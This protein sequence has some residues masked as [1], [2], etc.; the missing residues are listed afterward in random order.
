MLSVGTMAWAETWPPWERHGR[1]APHPFLV[2]RLYPNQNRLI[3]PISHSGG[4]TSRGVMLLPVNLPSAF[5]PEGILS[6]AC[7][8]CL[9]DR[10]GDHCGLVV[11]MTLTTFTTAGR[12]IGLLNSS[13]LNAADWEALRSNIQK[14]MAR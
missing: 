14:E 7:T 12:V 11:S 4:L 2:A 10:L 13:R 9:K 1:V 6:D 8:L 5:P 3:L